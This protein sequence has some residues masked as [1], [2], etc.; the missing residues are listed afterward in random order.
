[1]KYRKW[2]QGVAVWLAIVAGLTLVAWAQM[3]DL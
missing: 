2:A 1:M 3:R